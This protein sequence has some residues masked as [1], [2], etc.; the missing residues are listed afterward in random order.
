MY[1]EATPF[2]LFLFLFLFP[3]LSSCS[4]SCSSFSFLSFLLLLF[5][6]FFLALLF[7]AGISPVSALSFLGQCGIG[8]LAAALLRWWLRCTAWWHC[9]CPIHTWMRCSM[10]HRQS[11]TAPGS[12]PPGTPKSPLSPER[13]WL[14]WPHFHTCVDGQFFWLLSL[15]AQCFYFSFDFHL[16]FTAHTANGCVKQRYVVASAVASALEALHKLVFG[17]D[18]TP[19]QAFCTTQGLRIINSAFTPATYLVALRIRKALFPKVANHKADREE[20]RGGGRRDG[21]EVKGEA[22]GEVKGGQGREVERGREA[23]HTHTH[24]HAFHTHTLVRL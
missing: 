19:P 24:T 10:S 20:A 5:S 13:M 2:L 23:A 6:F 16:I 21:K 15:L 22:K 18:G 8:S 7:L 14:H 4:S 17:L 12:F 1:E 11:S 9:M 3:L